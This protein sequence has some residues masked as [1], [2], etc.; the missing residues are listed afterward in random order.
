MLRTSKSANIDKILAEVDEL[1]EHIGPEGIEQSP[2]L[3]KLKFDRGR[4]AA[5][6]ARR[7]AEPAKEADLL[8]PEGKQLAEAREVLQAP[9]LDL[10]PEEQAFVRA[11]MARA[12]RGTLIRWVLV[13]LLAVLTLLAGY[14][15]H[16]AGV[17]Q[18]EAESSAQAAEKARDLALA[19]S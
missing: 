1:L 19:E 18:K 13:A 10:T 7:Q 4:L 5:A 9:G 6:A 12:R 16:R 2:T 15:W 17:A 14:Q 3:K 8:L 11:S